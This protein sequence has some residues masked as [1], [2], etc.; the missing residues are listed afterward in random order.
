MELRQLKYFATTAR[1]MNFSEAARECNVTQSTLSQQISTL[2]G[3]I[4]AKLFERNN[5]SVA[6]T[7]MGEALLPHALKTLN[8]A[9]SCI[10]RIRDVRNLEEGEINIG[11]TYTFLPLI[12]EALLVFI[13]SHPNIKLNI[14][15]KDMSDLINMLRLRKI[16]VVFSHKPTDPIEGIESHVLFDSELCV[17]MGRTHPLAQKE[18][19]TPRDLEPY[20]ICLPAK[21]LQARHTLETVLEGYNETNLDVRLEIN[22]VNTLLGLVKKSNML[23][24]LSKASILGNTDVKAISL[25]A[26]GVD[27]QG[28]FHIMKNSYVKYSTRAFL[29]IL[30]EKNKVYFLSMMS[31]MNEI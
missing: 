14:E 21:G 7:D 10:D 1:T 6:L 9:T 5:H 25:N 3:E 20:P 13:K 29:K 30:C 2:E 12:M 19:L 22:D 31:F 16:D 18:N 15:C 17:V 27:L 26:P 23:T 28:S 8:E 11:T 4:G 24:F